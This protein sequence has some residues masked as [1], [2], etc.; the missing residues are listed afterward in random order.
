MV[1]EPFHGVK[2]RLQ[3]PQT[4]LDQLDSGEQMIIC[5]MCYS[6]NKVSV[7]ASSC[8]FFS[9]L[10]KTSENH[11]DGWSAAWLVMCPRASMYPS[12]NE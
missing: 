2:Y 1:A 8:F 7:L 10:Q 4:D 3:V 9:L 5:L 11:Y 6:P 12:I